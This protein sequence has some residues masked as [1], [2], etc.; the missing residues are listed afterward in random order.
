MKLTHNMFHKIDDSN[1]LLNWLD[2]HKNHKKFEDYLCHLFHLFNKNKDIINSTSLIQKFNININTL[3][4]YKQQKQLATLLI[5]YYLL[6][7]NSDKSLEIYK[8]M[9]S[10]N[11]H[12]SRHLILI[13]TWLLENN[14]NEHIFK[15][16]YLKEFN[17]NFIPTNTELSLILKISN[18]DIRNILL[19]TLLYQPLYYEINNNENIEQD[20]FNPFNDIR[21]LKKYPLSLNNINL[22]KENI[23]KIFVDQNKLDIYD[24][25]TKWLD[26]NNKNYDVIID[27]ANIL[28][29]V[30][31]KISP[32]SYKRLEQIIYYMNEKGYSILLILH[33]RHFDINKYKKYW[34][35]IDYL[36]VSNLIK[37]WLSDSHNFK[38][39]RTPYKMNDDLFLILGSLYSDDIKQI[40]TNDKFRDHIFNI[41]IKFGNYDL[42]YQWKQ[43]YGINYSFNLNEINLYT[44]YYSYIIQKSE[45]GYYIPT[46]SELWLFISK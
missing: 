38:L 9:K 42:I 32:N 18:K 15:E 13:L 46:S 43:D 36:Y 30:D 1:E 10:I 8:Y 16:L 39:Y 23:R 25:Y 37:S 28:F 40:L 5:E 24:S 12:K 19:D 34:S 6:N 4:L 44:S 31:G 2:N 11:E 33:M 3:N 14:S 7:K 45:I 17:N 22:I 20:I 27:G 35:K 26:L 41:S 29:S 21:D